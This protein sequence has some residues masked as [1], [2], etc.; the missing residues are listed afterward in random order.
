MATINLSDLVPVRHG[1]AVLKVRTKT[2]RAKEAAPGTR[3][4]TGYRGCVDVTFPKRP[5]ADYTID[6][7]GAALRLDRTDAAADAIALRKDIIAQN[8]VT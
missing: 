3:T 2:V 4:L 8:K 7:D 5:E 1:E 6:V